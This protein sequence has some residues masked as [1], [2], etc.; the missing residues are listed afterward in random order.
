MLQKFQDQHLGNLNIP[1]E[2]I[3]TWR[4]VKCRHGNNFDQRDENM[5]IV[6]H[7]ITI[8]EQSGETTQNTK[9]Y[10]TLLSPVKNVSNYFK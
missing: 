3:P 2:L 9:V 1:D 10:G 8:F 7:E 5:I 4:D 6:S